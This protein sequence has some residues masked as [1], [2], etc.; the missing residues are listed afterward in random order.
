MNRF[1]FQSALHCISSLPPTRFIVPVCSFA[2]INC[3]KH[4]LPS[5]LVPKAWQS[6][7][8]KSSISWF[9]DGASRQAL[10]HLDD[11]MVCIILVLNG[12]LQPYCTF[13]LSKRL[14][15][16]RYNQAIQIH[17]PDTTEMQNGSWRSRPF[18]ELKQ[19]TPWQ[20][21]ACPWTAKRMTV[22]DHMLPEWL[23]QDPECWLDLPWLESSFLWSESFRI[24]PWLWLRKQ[25][26]PSPISSE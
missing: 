9:A 21:D 17:S 12:F 19:E 4:L 15:N 10:S 6:W 14:E 3:S 24:L 23:H 5:D 7:H 20:S 13:T 2:K 22:V 8:Q 25:Q 18:H 11:C 16:K 26:Y 1:K